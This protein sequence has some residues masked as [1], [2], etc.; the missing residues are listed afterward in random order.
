MIN[1]Y[2]SIVIFLCEHNRDNE[3]KKFLR[4][5]KRGRI[6]VF[7][8]AVFIDFIIDYITSVRCS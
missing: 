6:R 8:I 7:P 1:H 3:R 2:H 4:I 5:F